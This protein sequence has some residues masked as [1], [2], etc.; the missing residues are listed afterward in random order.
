LWH[1]VE[2][3]QERPGVVTQAFTTMFRP[4]ITYGHNKTRNT[5]QS[6]KTGMLMHNRSHESMSYGGN[7]G[8]ALP[9]T[10]ALMVQK[11]AEPALVRMAKNEVGRGMLVSRRAWTS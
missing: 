9:H 4:I 2:A 7:G 11:A 8:H 5:Q 1:P 3:W 6:T 10:L